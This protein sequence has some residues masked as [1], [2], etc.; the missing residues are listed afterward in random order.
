M[1]RTS[2]TAVVLA[3]DRSS[4]IL[5]AEAA[6]VPSK[7]LVLPVGTH[8]LRVLDALQEA[9]E[10]KAVISAALRRA[11]CGGDGRVRGAYSLQG[12]DLGSEDAG[13]PSS[14]TSHVSGPPR[15][16]PVLVTTAITLSDCT[17]GGP[18]LFPRLVRPRRR[19]SWD[20]RLPR[21][22]GRLPETRGQ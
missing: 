12:S 18:L 8:V 15:R 19:L 7:C 21:G 5:C 6:G 3:G 22:A 17:H 10:V 2:Y 16:E 1:N 4:A 11:R 14:S 9:E 13:S 20:W